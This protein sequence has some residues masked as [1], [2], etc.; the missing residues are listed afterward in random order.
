M[1]ILS[2]FGCNSHERGEHDSHTR[3]EHDFLRKEM[4]LSRA[5]ELRCSRGCGCGC[6]DPLL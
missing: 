4:K 2:A 6:G 5:E 3:G 1:E